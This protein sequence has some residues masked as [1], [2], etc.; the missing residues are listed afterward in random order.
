MPSK[1]YQAVETAIT[2]KASGGDVTF[3]PKNIANS[4]GRISARADLGAWSKSRLYRWYGETQCQA[5]PTVGRSV[6]IYFAGWDEDTPASAIGDV[7]ST[8]AAFSTE[9]DLLDLSFLGQI[10]VDAAT[11]SVKFVRGGLI[12]IPYRYVSIV[13]W[14]ATGASLTNVDADHIFRLTPFVP[15]QQ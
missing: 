2:F 6:D 13:W 15:E 7:G 10:F 11:A 12:L 1:L 14:N 4:A 5:T 3:T 9:N 8:D